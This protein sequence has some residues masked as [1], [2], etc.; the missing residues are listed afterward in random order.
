M[1]TIFLFVS[2]FQHLEFFLPKNV[3]K[4][5]K[6]RKEKK[7]KEKKRKEK[8]R[9][10]KKRKEKEKKRKEKKRKEKKRKEKKLNKRILKN[11]QQKHM[12]WSTGRRHGRRG[13]GGGGRTLPRKV[14]IFGKWCTFETPRVQLG[15]SC[16]K[17]T[18]PRSD[19]VSPNPDHAALLKQPRSLWKPS[20]FS[21]VGSLHTLR[22]SLPLPDHWGCLRFR[23]D[24]CGSRGLMQTALFSKKKSCRL[25]WWPS[26]HSCPTGMRVVSFGCRRPK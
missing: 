9:K 2:C 6:K 21:R 18:Q 17:Q 26:S 16:C 14:T 15:N 7:R 12:F 5:E 25:R 24:S 13:E 20:A 11:Q 10:E 19:Q 22:Y 3:H 1:I 8:K 4:K 23:C